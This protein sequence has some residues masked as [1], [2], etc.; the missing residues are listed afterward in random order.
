[1][2]YN[3]TIILIDNFFFI[4]LGLNPKWSLLIT[5]INKFIFMHIL[6]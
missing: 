6:I 1:M 5:T 2:N 4:K 3:Y